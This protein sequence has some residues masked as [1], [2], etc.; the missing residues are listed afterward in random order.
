MITVK[1]LGKNNNYVNTIHK[2]ANAL[3]RDRSNRRELEFPPSYS[4][5]SIYSPA[6]PCVGSQRTTEMSVVMSRS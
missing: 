4:Y 2:P 5:S 1:N 6:G 3:I